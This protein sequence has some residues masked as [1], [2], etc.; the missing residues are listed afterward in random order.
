MLSSLRC[1]LDFQSDSPF[2]RGIA[3]EPTLDKVIYCTC[4]SFRPLRE[5]AFDPSVTQ[6][7]FLLAVFDWNYTFAMFMFIF[8]EGCRQMPK[9]GSALAVPTGSLWWG[10]ESAK[11]LGVSEGGPA[12]TGWSHHRNARPQR[13]VT[14]AYYQGT[15]TLVWHWHSLRGLI[16]H[17]PFQFLF[18]CSLSSR[19]SWRTNVV[20]IF[21][22]GDRADIGNA[23]W[24]SY[25]YIFF[26]FLFPPKNI[27]T[28]SVHFTGWCCP[29]QILKLKFILCMCVCSHQC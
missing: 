25:I 6:T 5:S 21:H 24:K 14:S 9:Q 2:L 13:K 4:R 3:E 10:F 28:S 29:N 19:D 16:P 26:F 20:C 23:D 15:A 7:L 1:C 11:V 22:P 12:A 17:C 8:L 27:Q 18:H